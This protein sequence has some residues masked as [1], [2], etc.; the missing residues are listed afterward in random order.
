MWKSGRQ[1]LWPQNKW[2]QKEGIHHL[3]FPW[4]GKGL[5]CCL[6]CVTW[7]TFSVTFWVRSLILLGAMISISAGEGGLIRSE[8]KVRLTW[9][10][11]PMVLSLIRSESDVEFRALGF[12]S[13]AESISNMTPKQFREII[14]GIVMWKKGKRMNR[15][16]KNVDKILKNISILQMS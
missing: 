6:T 14:N 11:R 12:R 4:D 13:A 7:V 8:P 9:G 2:A 10:M 3:F 1:Y 5:F 15:N 16:L